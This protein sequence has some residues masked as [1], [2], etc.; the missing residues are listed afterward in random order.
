MRRCLNIRERRGDRPVEADARLGHYRKALEK[1]LLKVMSKMGIAT[2]SLIV[3]RKFLRRWGWEGVGRFLFLR[4]LFA[5]RW[6]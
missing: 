2:F 6:H 4:D 5:G 1:G 3:G